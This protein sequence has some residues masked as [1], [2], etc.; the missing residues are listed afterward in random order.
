MPYERCSW[1]EFNEFQR[2][3]DEAIALPMVSLFGMIYDRTRWERQQ[4]GKYNVVTDFH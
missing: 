2:K 4:R 3:E 1:I